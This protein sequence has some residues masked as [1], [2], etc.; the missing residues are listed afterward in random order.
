MAKRGKGRSKKLRRLLLA[1]P[2]WSLK[3]GATTAGGRTAGGSKS[4][5]HDI[6]GGVR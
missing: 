1:Q 4:P 5:S 6:G 2:A 3:H